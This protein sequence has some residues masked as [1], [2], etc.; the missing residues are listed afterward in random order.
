MLPSDKF[1]IRKLT[2]G[3]HVLHDVK[4]FLN[5]DG[6]DLVLGGNVLSLIEFVGSRSTTSAI[7][8][9]FSR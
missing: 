9:F 3:K 2:I 1:K 6:T 5:T 8:W 7:C 4:G